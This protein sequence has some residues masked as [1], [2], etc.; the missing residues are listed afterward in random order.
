MGFRTCIS[1]S[2][3]H[4]WQSWPLSKQVS[5]PSFHR[6]S[7]RERGC[8]VSNGDVVIVELKPDKTP[9]E[10]T[11]QTLSSVKELS[12]DKI[13]EIANGYLKAQGPLEDAVKR[14][15]GVELPDI[16]N[17]H[18]NMMIVASEVDSSTE[19]IINYLSDTYPCILTLLNAE[20]FASCH[21]LHR[22]K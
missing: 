14:G 22:F 13:T 12:N 15:F 20:F 19:R 6:D 21:H 9:L 4:S 5:G 2:P 7:D 10:I 18:H 8:A 1:L 17:E 16:L 3:E 11:A